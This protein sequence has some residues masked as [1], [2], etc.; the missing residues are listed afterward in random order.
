MS[1]ENS[2]DRHTSGFKPFLFIFGALVVVIIIAKVVL[3]LLG[4]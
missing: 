4:I 3:N 2:T 1:T